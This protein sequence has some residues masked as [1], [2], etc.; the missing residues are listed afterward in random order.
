MCMSLP[1]N[2]S[3]TLILNIIIYINILNIIHSKICRRSTSWNEYDMPLQDEGHHSSYQTSRFTFVMQCKELNCQLSRFKYLAMASRRLRQYK[4]C[5]PQKLMVYNNCSHLRL[6]LPISRTSISRDQMCAC[7]L[8]SR[9]HRGAYRGW[10]SV[11]SI[12]K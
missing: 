4:L 7:A 3:S 11:A 1:S 10:V 8:V 12:H 9:Q 5:A 6:C 2:F